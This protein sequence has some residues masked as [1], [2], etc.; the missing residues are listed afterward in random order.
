MHIFLNT[1]NKW[2]NICFDVFMMSHFPDSNTSEQAP[3]SFSIHSRSL[4]TLEDQASNGLRGFVS[5]HLS[6]YDCFHVANAL[7]CVTWRTTTWHTCATTHVTHFA[8]EL[9]MCKALKANDAIKGFLAHHLL[10]KTCFQEVNFPYSLATV[11]P[12]TRWA[13]KSQHLAPLPLAR[14]VCRQRMFRGVW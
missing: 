1:T 8:H 7:E 5:H 4:A 12:T 13:Y 3:L 14:W 9:W 10:R 2:V 6:V 11:G